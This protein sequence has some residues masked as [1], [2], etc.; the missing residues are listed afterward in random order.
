MVLS[1][2]NQRNI[3]VNSYEFSATI[4]SNFRHLTRISM[5]AP[6]C[7]TNYPHDHHNMTL[8]KPV[9]S[10]TELKQWPR[11]PPPSRL[12]VSSNSRLFGVITKSNQLSLVL[13][14]SGPSGAFRFSERHRERA[15]PRNFFRT[16]K[17]TDTADL[18]IGKFDQR[19]LSSCAMATAASFVS[20]KL[21]SSVSL[22]DSH[23]AT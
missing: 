5:S 11:L 15:L 21:A 23:C 14:L 18:F 10:F 17:T 2:R 1:V 22:L 19:A 9:E 3:A 16:N 8:F 13:F 12:E 7:P 6:G 20:C 4:H